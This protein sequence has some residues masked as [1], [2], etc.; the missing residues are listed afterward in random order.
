MPER[1]DLT[2]RTLL[3]VIPELDAGGAERTTLE[4]AAAI[5][6][7]GGRALVASRGGRLED[8]L[9]GLGGEL[10][11]LDM[12]SKNPLVVASN[13]R[14][15]ETLIA[16]ESVDLIHARSRACA[17]SAWIAARRTSTRFVTTIHGAYSSGGLLKRRY[18][19]V[20]GK[21]DRV[22]ANSDW[23]AARARTEYGVD[24]ARL[25]TIPRG[26]DLARFDPNAVSRERIRDARRAFGVQSDETRRILF[27]PARLTSWKGQHIAVDAMAA[28][29]EDEIDRT[30]LIFAGDDQGRRDYA[31]RLDDRIDAFGL[32][33]SVWRIDHVADMP[34]ALAASD[35]VL[36][37]SVRPEAFGRIAVEAG[38]MGKPV[39]VSDHGGARETVVDGETG[40]RVAPGDPA[41]LAGAIRLLMSLK[42][43]AFTSMGEAGRKRVSERYTTAGLQA[44]TL[45]VYT[46]LLDADSGSRAE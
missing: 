35:I 40:V 10:V 14:R 5:K 39:I 44:A 25:A 11:R 43:P 13:A 31:R 29:A 46:D 12:K 9:K 36:A 15:L 4:V 41:A 3:Q 19:S 6:D 8:E 33:T 26:V 16:A 7:A 37:P 23:I 17:W 21:G 34:A 2:G 42:G 45:R 22:I 28:L 24:P 18:N 32:K 20:V 27:F 38:A 30:V 1:P